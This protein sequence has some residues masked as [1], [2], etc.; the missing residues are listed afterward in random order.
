MN[1]IQKQA[2][3]DT[4]DAMFPDKTAEFRDAMSAALRLNVEARNHH[5]VDVKRMSLINRTMWQTY[6]L[7]LNGPK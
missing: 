3:S 1:E 4:M 6:N 5:N 2:I 7:I